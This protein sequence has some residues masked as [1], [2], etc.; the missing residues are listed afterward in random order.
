MKTINEFIQT[1][2]GGAILMLITFAI[3]VILLSKFG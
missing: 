3:V 1:P 2:V